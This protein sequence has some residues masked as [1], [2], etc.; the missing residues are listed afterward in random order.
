[1]GKIEDICKNS[2]A[3]LKGEI[4]YYWIYPSVK[5][6]MKLLYMKTEWGSETPAHLWA[7]LS[8]MKEYAF[9][10]RITDFYEMVLRFTLSECF[11][12]EYD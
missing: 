6:L 3:L 9:K 2:K 5:D 4:N 1:M 11:D 7:L 12:E 10:H 8:A